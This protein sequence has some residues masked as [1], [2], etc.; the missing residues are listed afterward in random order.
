MAPMKTRKSAA[1]NAKVTQKT[2]KKGGKEQNVVEKNAEVESEN[3]DTMESAA[4]L[5]LVAN[6]LTDRN[7]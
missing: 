2:P 7:R 4:E 3:G 5:Y 6:H 1:S